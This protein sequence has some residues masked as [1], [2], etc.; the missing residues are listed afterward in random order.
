MQSQDC[1]AES[2]SQVTRPH[3]RD[4]IKIHP[5]AE[6]IP[7]MSEVDFEELVKDIGQNGLQVGLVLLHEG[8]ERD[9][10]A[11]PRWLIDGRHRIEAAW[12]AFA[13]DPEFREAILDA[14]LDGSD[15][16]FDWNGH[17]ITIAKP[18]V[19][20]THR[21]DAIFDEKGLTTGERGIFRNPDTDPHTY[22]ISANLH[23]RHLS[24]EKKQEL[25]ETLLKAKPKRSDREIAKLAK[26]DHKTV[27]AVRERLVTTGEIPHLDKTTGA[28]GK[29]RPATRR[30]KTAK[31]S[32]SRIK[33]PAA[34][35]RAKAIVGFAT[36]LHR[37]L[38]E[39][40]DDLTRILRDERS[41]IAKIP[42]QKRIV[43]ARGYLNAL[44]ITLDDL[45]PIG[46]GV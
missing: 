1:S 43:L 2:G 7:P 26:V 9:K 38:A 42:P 28:D 11:P 17:S 35:V 18:V 4:R 12:L 41:Q 14:M 3:W 25:L 44:D 33:E 22:V 45:R 15:E 13:D 10:K 39:T 27:G 46:G 40:L 21:E 8:T 6:M 34:Q 32:L 20:Y 16:S 37:Q 30:S 5:A 19:L 31:A 23:R 29:A 36:L 24:R